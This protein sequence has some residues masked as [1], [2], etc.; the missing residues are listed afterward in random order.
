M[1]LGVAVV[2]WNS[3]DDLRQLLRSLRP[4]AAELERVVVVDNGSTDGSQTELPAGL[5]L[6]LIEA[7]ENL[8]FAAAANRAIES[9]RTPFILLVNPDVEINSEGLQCLLRK[10]SQAPRA[11]IF[12]GQLF[13][14]QGNPQTEFQLRP[15]PT[16][17][18]VL[19]EV[20]FLEHA[21][22][23]FGFSKG[24]PERDFGPVRIEQPAAAL[25]L[26]RREAWEAVRGFD[27]QFFPA[28]F[29]DVDFCKRLNQAGW[30]I[31]YL[32]GCS[33]VHRGGVSLRT[34]GRRRFL[35]IYY[36]NMLRYLAKHHP[37]WHPWLWFPVQLGR[38]IRI[39]GAAQ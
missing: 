19:K 2:N 20:L 7:K 17:W 8:G 38:L 6:E 21:R 4:L 26:L 13:D 9:L 24:L 29:E 31:F 3:G 34:L 15:L 23:R 1:Q 11:A 25:W 35:D 12:T 32:P 36:R 14:R 37:F 5:P 18:G 33:F 22:R 30:R 10:I 16:P 39:M 28:W 27:E